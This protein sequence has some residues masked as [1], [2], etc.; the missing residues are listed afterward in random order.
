MKIQLDPSKDLFTREEMSRIWDGL[1]CLAATGEAKH[2][3]FRAMIGVLSR[4]GCRATEACNMQVKDVDLENTPPIVRIW[5]LKKKKPTQSILEVD[6]VLAGWLA[7]WLQVH[8]SDDQGAP[9]FHKVRSGKQWNR[10]ELQ[11]HWRRLLGVLGVKYRHLHAL[12]H[13]HGTD[14]YAATGNLPATQIRL[15]HSDIKTTMIYVD[16]RLE[17]R[18]LD[19]ARYA[20]SYT[21]SVEGENVIPMREVV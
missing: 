3:M 13:T 16:C 5:R 9:L 10:V 1:D 21:G 14:Y 7:E 20:E 6:S 12:R 15:G 4:V 19:I 8:P 17:T 2:L 11:Q 18:A